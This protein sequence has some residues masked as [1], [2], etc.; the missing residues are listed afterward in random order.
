MTLFCSVIVTKTMDRSAND[1]WIDFQIILQPL[2]A[3]LFI[4]QAMQMLIRHLNSLTRFEKKR[5]IF[6]VLLTRRCSYKSI[7]VLAK[8]RTV[9]GSATE[10]QLPFFAFLFR[11]ETWQSLSHIKIERALAR[12]FNLIY[13]LASMQPNA[14]AENQFSAS[15]FFCCAQL[16]RRCVNRIYRFSIN[17]FF[18]D[19]FSNW[20]SKQIVH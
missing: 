8:S 13:V 6:H 1:M 14:D 7:F 12:T 5:I 11:S 10:S 4:A 17:I 15:T 18:C 20:H 19:S 3:N 16:F 2:Y 9:H